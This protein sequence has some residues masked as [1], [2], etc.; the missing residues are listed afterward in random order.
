M[1]GFE[2]VLK[3][4]KDIDWENVKIVVNI[5]GGI[6]VAG[7]EI[8]E[9]LSATDQMDQITYLEII[10]PKD[11]SIAVNRARLIQSI[12]DRDKI[13]DPLIAL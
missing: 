11:A 12:A 13:K 3:S 4:L 9:I 5:A 2:A 7:K 1:S 6:I 8:I 10:K